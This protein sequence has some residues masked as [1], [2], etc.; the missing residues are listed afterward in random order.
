MEKLKY[1]VTDLN[2]TLVDAMPTYTKI[3]CD[4]LKRRAGIDS[5]EVARY[6]V[7][8]SGVDCLAQRG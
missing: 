8:R 4:I 1:I 3:F 5:P 7:A 2:G 6:P